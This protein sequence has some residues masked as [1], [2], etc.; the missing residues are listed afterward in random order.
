MDAAVDGAVSSVYVCV[1][2]V[3]LFRQVFAESSEPGGSAPESTPSRPG[4]AKIAVSKI[5]FACV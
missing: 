5:V 4:S 1:F 3:F 2:V